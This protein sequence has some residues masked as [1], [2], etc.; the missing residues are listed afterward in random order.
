MKKALNIIVIMLWII[1]LVIVVSTSAFA[2]SGRTDASGGHRDNKN[3][4]VL[5]SYH[6]VTVKGAGG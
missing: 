3:V 6:Y 4:S 2:H 1:G 5:G